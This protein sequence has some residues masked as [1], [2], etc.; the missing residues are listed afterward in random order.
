M[1]LQIATVLLLMGAAVTLMTLDIFRA[2]FVA[3]ALAVVLT[4]VGVV[5]PQ[6]AFSGFASTAAVTIM[7]VFILTSGLYRT[8]ITRQVGRELQK[9]A[10]AEPRRLLVLTMLV[11]G[12]LSLFMNNVAATALLMPAVMDIS[13][14]TKVSPSKLMM[15][16]AFSVNLGGAATLLATSNI[17]VSSTLTKLGLRPFGFLEF[18][19]LGLPMLGVGVVY[20]LLVG[21]HL[22]PVHGLAAQ[23]GRSQMRGDLSK[24]YALEARMTELRVPD[25]SA[26]VGKPV[27]E[28]D[29]GREYG[30]S[31]L[32]V[33]RADGAVCTAPQAD[34]VLEPD[35]VLVV[36]GRFERAQALADT[37]AVVL[38][39]RTHENGLENGQIA[40]IEAIVAPRSNAVGHSLQDLRFRETYGLSVVALWRDGRPYRTDVG[41]MTLRFGDGLLVHGPRE[42][43]TLLQ[44]N[45]DY[46]V[47]TESDEPLRTERA[48]VAGVIMIVALVVAA[49]DWL[50]LA[51][52]MMAGAL[53]MVA[54]G[55]LDMDMAY[56]SIEW[57]AIFLIAGM[58]PCGIA[59][60]SSGTADWLSRVII[61]TLGRYPPVVLSTGVLLLA[62][63]LT[64]VMSGQVTAV[65]LTP[66]AVAAATQ[67]GITPHSL[68]MA[69]AMG[70]SM[71][72]IT[73]TAHPANVLVMGPGGY[74]FSD[75]A[76]VGAPLTILTV[77]TVVILLPIFFPLT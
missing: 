9:M 66:I 58:L 7:A 43:I 47:L 64:Q 24:T 41:R 34:L 63:L 32:A 21:R 45:P 1:T 27:G 60:S 28:S 26:L 52:S 75:F 42:R 10:G 15:P 8:G 5:T 54:L 74:R 25:G 23:F 53:L 70:C 46:L 67:L 33:C 16:L 38:E 50:P 77:L 68:A 35:D 37:G 44:R 20:V 56:R 14:R 57:R 22:L 19:P 62:M 51:V 2:D 61:D 76:R 30:L 48:W 59:M 49:L 31:I 4:L 65:V 29:V 18:A 11:G 72:F 13:R 12:G 3:L 40:L 39:P 17:L 69:V 6:E 71:V 55:C 73:P 36:T